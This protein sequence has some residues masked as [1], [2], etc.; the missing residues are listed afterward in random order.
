MNGSADAAT[1]IAFA[2]LATVAALV[3][4]AI[5]GEG[6]AARF[7]SLIAASVMLLTSDFVWQLVGIGAQIVSTLPEGA[8][9]AAQVARA[10]STSEIVV[11]VG[12]AL[13]AA[14]GIILASV[15]AGHRFASIRQN[16]LEVS[17]YQ[18]S[19]AAEARNKRLMGIL[20]REHE[21]LRSVR[22]MH[23][24]LE[25]ATRNSQITVLFQ[26]L[27]LRYQW[28]VNPRPFLIPEDIVGKSDE[29]AFPEHMRPLVVGHKTRAL[30]TGT[31]QTFE[32]EI[33]GKDERAWFRMDVVPISNDDKRLTGLVCTAI[34][35]SRSKRLD[36]MR[37]DLS[38][39]LAETLQRFNLALRS[40]KIM[41]FSQDTD[42]RYTWANSDETQ[43]GSIIGRTDD[44]V[45]PEADR[46]VITE[47]KKS[48][49]ESK[50]PLSGEI[51][52]GEGAERRWYDLHIEPN[53]K[54]DGTVVGITCAS[55]DITHRKRNE[56][57]MR[58]VMRELTHRTKNLLTVVIAIARQTSTQSPTVEAFVPALIARLRAL[59]AAQDLIVADEWAGVDIGDLVRVLVGQ[60]IP[61]HSSRVS[62][63]GPQ[64]VL[65]PEASQNLGLA[66][67]ELAA[68]AVQYG[69]FAN[70]KGMLE[71]SWSVQQGQ[72]GTGTMNFTWV[73]TGG[74]AVSEPTRRGFGMTVIERNLSRA[75]RAE[76]NL[77]F[78]PNGLVANMTLPLE[79]IVPFASPDR[80]MLAQ[81][82]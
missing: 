23:R 26:D 27:D 10:A 33:P 56:E 67:H 40:E 59:S 24:Y 78:T 81:A 3:L 75:L 14:V 12:A 42:L 52:V 37:T 47:L 66:I 77:D 5:V 64:V 60:F 54:P 49:I 73:E 28:V 18:S 2:E 7:L 17:K 45:I 55:I 32:I 69:A 61:P 8:Q 30:Q 62:I 53:L 63:S 6:R 44:E 79:G 31:T 15:L 76:V 43:I 21:K 74:P 82:S 34:D 41:V 57:Q 22:E 39:R 72:D 9:A 29:E 1:T 4:F 19:Q 70:A 16:R 58:L 65:S 71:V 80:T 48:V 46:P 13:A 38:R 51:G 20:Q 50:R 36:M 35:I 11:A 68:N 25:L